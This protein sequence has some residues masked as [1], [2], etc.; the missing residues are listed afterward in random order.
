MNPQNTKTSSKLIS[1]LEAL[2]YI[3]VGRTN[4]YEIL[5]LGHIKPVKIGRRTFVIKSELDSW[6]DSLPRIGGQ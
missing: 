4:S 1:V 6:I 3:G 5:K 2:S